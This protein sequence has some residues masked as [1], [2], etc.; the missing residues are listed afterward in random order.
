MLFDLTGR[1]RGVVRV[2][3][4][5]LAI[6]LA[7][8]LL[9]GVGTATGVNPFTDGGGSGSVED[10][11]AERIERA[12]AAVDRDPRDPAAL[13]GLI[14]ARVDSA[15]ATADPNTG[16][17]TGPGRAELRRADRLWTRYLALDPDEPDQRVAQRMVVA[18][19]ETGLAQPAKAADAQ[20]I[21]VTDALDRA[22]A[23]D[24]DPPFQPTAVLAQLLYQAGDERRGDLAA[25]RA[26]SLAPAAQRKPLRE[27]L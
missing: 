13:A 23:A 27:Q 15:N 2:V 3:Y 11:T 12:Q 20:E 14:R 4:S 16:S 22:R 6:L 10:Q 17:Y 19:G 25:R 24:L 8:G 7:G 21:V 9:V 1:R 5:I 26:A 18:Y